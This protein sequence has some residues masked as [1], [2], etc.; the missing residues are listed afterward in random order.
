MIL[1]MQLLMLRELEGVMVS[2]KEAYAMAA[3]IKKAK[4]GLIRKGNI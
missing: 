3:F 4:Q 1:S 2:R